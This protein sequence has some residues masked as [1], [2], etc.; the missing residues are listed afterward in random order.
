MQFVCEVDENLKQ[1]TFYC[2]E[3][4]GPKYTVKYLLLRLNLINLTTNRNIISL[5]KFNMS[6]A[7]RNKN[8]DIA[9]K[10]C[11]VSDWGVGKTCKCLIN[12]VALFLIECKVC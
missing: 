10:T 12:S 1:R 2:D 9:I 11:F 6:K 4:L 5:N 8:G 3:I 7:N